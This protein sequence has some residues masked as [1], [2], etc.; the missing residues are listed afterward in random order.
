[1]NLKDR[2]NKTMK[3][4]PKSVFDALPKPVKEMVIAAQYEYK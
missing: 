2:L 3:E 1:M 4:M